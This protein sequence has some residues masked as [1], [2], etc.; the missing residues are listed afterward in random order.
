MYL[1]DYNKLQTKSNYTYI[2]L[3]TKITVIDETSDSLKTEREG[4]ITTDTGNLFHCEAKC[5]TKE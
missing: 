4:E 3:T 2:P 5:G 1:V